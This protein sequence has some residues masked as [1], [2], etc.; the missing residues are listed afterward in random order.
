MSAAVTPPNLKLVL[1]RGWM[2]SDVLGA[3]RSSRLRSR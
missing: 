3:Q 2:N 1:E